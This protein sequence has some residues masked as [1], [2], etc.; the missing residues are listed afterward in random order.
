MQKK[1]LLV[2]A[3]VLATAG[4]AGVR[5]QT[6][7]K[8][9]GDKPQTA[10]VDAWRQSLPEN[11]QIMNAPPAAVMEESRDNVE[12]R[13]TAAETEKRILDLEQRFTEALKQRDS[14]ALK[15][16]LA[17]DFVPA[18]AGITGAQPNKDRFIE[19]AQK[20][21]DFKSY[22]AEK[23]TVRLYQ[24]TAVVTIQYKQQPAATGSAAATGGGFIATDV[25]V[26]RGKLWQAVSHHI[27]QLPK[28]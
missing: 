19:L 11:E 14:A 9:E 28:P 16:L 5:A 4:G 8:K 24:R 10:T 18:G 21:L 12:T 2:T 13:E 25:W 3:F 17:D 27:S 20:N 6:T 22:V 1:I 23:T 26:K 15:Y 7:E